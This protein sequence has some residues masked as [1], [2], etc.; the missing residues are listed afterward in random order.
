M[1]QPTPPPASHHNGDA[2]QLATGEPHKHDAADEDVHDANAN[3]KADGDDAGDGNHD[4]N[5]NY[6]QNDDH[7]SDQ[8][9]VLFDEWRAFVACAAWR[10]V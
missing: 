1:T 3:Y 6:F 9:Q 5:D 7:D 10:D 4:D 8:R 2:S